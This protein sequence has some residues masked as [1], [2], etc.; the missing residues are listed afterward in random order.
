[1]PEANYPETPIPLT[2]SSLLQN[3]P[4]CPTIDKCLFA[5]VTDEVPSMHRAYAT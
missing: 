1:M 3:P 4:S 5:K 2:F